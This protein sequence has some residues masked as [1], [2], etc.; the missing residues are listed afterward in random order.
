MEHLFFSIFVGTVVSLIVFLFFEKKA[1]SAKRLS[2]KEGLHGENIT[3]PESFQRYE[4]EKNII[5]YSIS[6]FLFTIVLSYTSF[7]TQNLTLIDVFLYVFL[8][9][10]I[11]S[12]II[13]ILKLRRSILIKVF[14]AF[15]YGAP[16]IFSSALGFIVTYIVYEKFIL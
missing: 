3:L 13:F 8:T 9:T 6:M 10:F 15:L 11:G 7:F 16:L 5:R 12:T 14:A 2:Q 4:T 1:I